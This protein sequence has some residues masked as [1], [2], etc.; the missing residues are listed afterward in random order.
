[1][2]FLNHQQYYL[3][4]PSLMFATPGSCTPWCGARVGPGKPGRAGPSPDLTPGRATVVLGGAKGWYMICICYICLQHTRIT[5][6]FFGGAFCISKSHLCD[7]I[8]NM[9]GDFICQKI[10]FISSYANHTSWF[11]QVFQTMHHLSLQQRSSI[12]SVALHFKLP[13][14]APL[15]DLKRSWKK[16]VHL[17]CVMDFIITWVFLCFFSWFRTRSLEVRSSIQLFEV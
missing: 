11:S 4:D 16:H 17:F 3:N 9:I 5:W 14:T 15:D 12:C 2:G 1:M 7:M 8:Y 13:E 6:H 10:W